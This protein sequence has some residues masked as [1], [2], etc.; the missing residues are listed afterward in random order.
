[1][2]TQALAMPFTIYRQVSVDVLMHFITCVLVFYAA[3]WYVRDGAAAANVFAGLGLAL[4]VTC[5]M[6]LEQY[7]GGLE[8]TRQYAAQYFDVSQF[9]PELL[10]RMTSDRVF[11]TLGYPNALGGF[12]ALV[13]VP[14]LGWIWT[15]GRSWVPFVKWLTLVLAGGLAVGCLLM[16]GSRGGFAAFASAVLVALWCLLPR[17]SSRGAVA[18]LAVVVI[19]A[20]VFFAAQRGGLIRAGMSSLEAR[21][22][23]WGGAVAIIRDHPWVGT[24]PG[25]FGSVYPL[26]KTAMTEEAQSVHNNFLQMWSDSGVLAFVVFATMWVVGLRDAFRLAMNRQSDVAAAGL[27][28]AMVAWTVHGM[29]DFDLYVPGLAVPSFLMLGTVQG[30]KVM[31]KLDVVSRTPGK[32]RGMLAA[33]CISGMLIGFYITGSGLRAAFEHGEA[34]ARTELDP[35]GALRHAREAVELAPGNAHY[36]AFVAELSLEQR[37]FDDAL[38][39]YR[40][41]S[42]LDPYRASYYWRIAR[43]LMTVNGVNQEALDYLKKAVALNR[44]S[45][46]YAAELAAAEAQMGR[47][48]R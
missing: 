8:A 4:F 34:H 47:E 12:I 15:R 26:Y 7:M 39:A 28:A 40:E 6:A 43:V 20:G 35:I 44:T 17:R 45:E 3:A 37:R 1:M 31:P 19:M 30:L 10:L 46:R 23:Y 42:R 32:I 14:T 33:V 27:C 21:V 13:F 16:S 24:G 11:G 5:V 18:V 9:S 36:W 29:I 48:N 38:E 22:D 2:A 41:A 25:T